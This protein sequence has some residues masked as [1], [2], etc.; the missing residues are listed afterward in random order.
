MG[1]TAENNAVDSQHEK[2]LMFCVGHETT[3]RKDGDEQAQTYEGAKKVS[4]TQS[5]SEV[6]YEPQ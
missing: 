1:I 6:L 4:E 3:T 2:L 5:F